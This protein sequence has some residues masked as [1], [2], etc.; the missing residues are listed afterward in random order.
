MDQPKYAERNAVVLGVSVD[1]ID[2]HKKFCAKEGL[3]FKL[4]AD[5]DHQVS[6]LYGSLT[7]LGFAKFSAR[8][9]F[10]I[11]PNGNVAKVYSS[12]NPFNH[13]QE[14]LAGLDSLQTAAKL[15]AS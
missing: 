12:V 7:N 9:T 5:S 1:S 8:H 13:S 2:S 10:L 3:N 4:L 14:V 6:A 15:K 11:D